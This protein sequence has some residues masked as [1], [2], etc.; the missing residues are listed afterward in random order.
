MCKTSGNDTSPSAQVDARNLRQA[1]EKIAAE[2]NHGVGQLAGGI[3]TDGLYLHYKR[4]RV[5][6]VVCTSRLDDLNVGIVTFQDIVEGGFYS[7]SIEAFIGYG[8]QYG[9]PVKRFMYVGQFFP[10]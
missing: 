6:R 5:Y 8:E 10:G 9:H 1:S 3:Q 2:A 4:K 7:R